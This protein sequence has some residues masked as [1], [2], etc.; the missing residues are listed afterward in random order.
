[1]SGK[2]IYP[3]PEY[4]GN[5]L[6]ASMPPSMSQDSSS[7]YAQYAVPP[8][9]YPGS[10]SM[11]MSLSQSQ[12]RLSNAGLMDSILASKRAVASPDIPQQEDMHS[13]RD[14]YQTSES[15]S[16][17]NSKS[18]RSSRSR[19]STPPSTPAR[20]G[21]LRAS[22][23]AASVAK[24]GPVGQTPSSVGPHRT[25][26]KRV[27][28]LQTSLE[29]PATIPG[30]P[31]R[32]NTLRRSTSEY[33]SQ[34]PKT[35][36]KLNTSTPL[37][38]L[39]LASPVDAESNAL[40]HSLNPSVLQSAQRARAAI[41]SGELD[42]TSIGMTRTRSS[43]G[44]VPNMAR[45]HSS[46]ESSNTGSAVSRRSSTLSSLQMSPL[47]IPQDS[48]A[49]RLAPSPN[50][51]AHYATAYQ[52]ADALFAFLSAESVKIASNPNQPASLALG[53][54]EQLHSIDALRSLINAR[55]QPGTV[56]SPL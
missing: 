35:L 13:M 4:G 50:S 5:P 7:M 3:V 29:S 11:A 26:S 43:P 24:D 17:R 23:S 51:A 30:Q 33:G 53:T 48:A 52:A 25:P 38:S 28:A 15:G 42:G 55:L 12:G 56:L 10:Q 47:P 40:R 21:T 37:A 2:G 46:S 16:R 54:H 27:Q 14:V 45:P 19:T 32:P 1:M 34:T 44:Y 31:Q 49:L 9:R 39:G 41:V 6:S 20:F 36:R 18:S 22:R 8:T